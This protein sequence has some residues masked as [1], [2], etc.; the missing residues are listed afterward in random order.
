MSASIVSIIPFHHGTKGL[1]FS[2]KGLGFLVDFSSLQ[3]STKT[4]KQIFELSEG[5]K[6]IGLKEINGDKRYCFKFFF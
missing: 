5:D 6:V 1:I 3:S 2:K 4:G